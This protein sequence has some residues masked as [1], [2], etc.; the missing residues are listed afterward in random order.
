[1]KYLCLEDVTSFGVVMIPK[2]AVVEAGQRF[3]ESGLTL[4]LS[5]LLLRDNPMFEPVQMSVSS[6]E[7]SEVADQ[8][9]RDWIVEVKVRTTRSRLRA[10]EHF[11]SEK[12]PGML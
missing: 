9:E 11:L 12:L 2:G 10:I 7:H 6:R 4:E 5:E 1:M 3:T 8:E